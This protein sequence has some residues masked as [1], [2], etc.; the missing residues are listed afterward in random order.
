VVAERRRHQRGAGVPSHLDAAAVGRGA[1]RLWIP[2]YVVG[3][4]AIDAKMVA[5]IIKA[6]GAAAWSDRAALRG[7]SLKRGALNTAKDLRI[8]P[9]RLKPL[10][11]HNS[12][13]PLA[14]YIEERDLFAHHA[15]RGFYR[16]RSHWR[17]LMTIGSD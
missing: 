6:R 8:H 13:T 5:R 3:L 1:S 17:W 12:Y 7:H 16:P 11:R 2:A 4:Q 9:A 10:G 14:A 15:L